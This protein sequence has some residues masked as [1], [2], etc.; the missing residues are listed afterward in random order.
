MKNIIPVIKNI[1]ANQLNKSVT[2]SI[3][4]LFFFLPANSKSIEIN[5]VLCEIRTNNNDNANND[6]EIIR[7]LTSVLSVIF[8]ISFAKP[9]VKTKAPLERYTSSLS[10]CSEEYSL[11]FRIIFLYSS[12]S[13]IFLFKLRKI[14]D[15]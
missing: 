13:C 2:T 11:V 5:E 1:N 6:H 14:T 12:F 7:S 15:Y 10:N 8:T 4:S 9:R 3:L